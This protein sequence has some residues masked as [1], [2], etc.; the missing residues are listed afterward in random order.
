MRVPWIIWGSGLGAG[1][2]AS[3]AL[4]RLIDL[5]PT[6][7]D[8]VD[9]KAPAPLEGRSVIPVVNG[10]EPEPTRA[11]VEAMDANLTRNWAPL[12]GLVTRGYKLI[13]LPV[14]ELY[15]L[16]AD[17]GESTNLFTRDRDR[18]RTLETLL[19]DTRQELVS[20]ASGA[21]KTMLS[22]EARQ[23]LQALGYVGSS[24]E[25][26]PRTFTEADDPKTLIVASNELNQ[27]TS[28]FN[29]G[30]RQQAMAAVQSIIRQHPGFTTA[31]GMYASMQRETGDLPGAIVTLEGVIRRGIADQ[32][33]SVV[34]AGYFQDSGNDQKAIDILQTVIDAHPDEVEAYNSL[35][36]AYSKVGRHEEARAAYR[37]VLQLD[38][39]SATAY[40]NLGV[41]ELRAGQRDRAAADLTRSLELD[42][43]LASAHNALAA[44]LAGQG[45]TDQAVAHWKTAV[46]LNPRL[47]D[48]LYNLGVTL[49]D[50]GAYDEAGPYLQRFVDTAPQA[51]YRRDIEQVRQMLEHQKK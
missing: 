5:A 16:V 38:P 42:P 29:A 23:R 22:D 12:T 40:E 11:Y 1:G 13:D 21:V 31:Y 39:T 51:R 2:I 50:A 3:D 34:L 35:G 45:H 27:A 49:N 26:G 25:A 8:L 43:N 20:H 28:A 19:R 47:Y 44:L 24:A 14:P 6:I 18:A 46:Q 36:S 41:D 33:V 10:R 37:K 30:S 32:R 7:L 17:P 4:V 15:D 9:V 48:A